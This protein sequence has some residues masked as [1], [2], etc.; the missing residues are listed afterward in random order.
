M[1]IADL[2]PSA[3]V[4][5]LAARRELRPTAGERERIEALVIARI[6]DGAPEAWATLEHSLPRA[7]ESAR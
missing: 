2:N 7:P 3:Q 6:G 4:V 5:I 1:P